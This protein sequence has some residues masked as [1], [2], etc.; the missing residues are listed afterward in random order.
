MSVT[1]IWTYNKSD[2]T[3]VVLQWRRRCLRK[4]KGQVAASNLYRSEPTH[5]ECA[6][7]RGEARSRCPRHVDWQFRIPDAHGSAE[8]TDVW[9]GSHTFRET[10]T[11]P[12]FW[13]G[14]IAQVPTVSDQT[15]QKPSHH[16][17]DTRVARTYAILSHRFRG[18]SLR[19]I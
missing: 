2:L 16:V 4:M 19:I 3:H 7:L 15:H 14:L 1:C 12:D 5:S 6:P 10:S 8:A 9:H 17:R 18:C 11:T 13:R